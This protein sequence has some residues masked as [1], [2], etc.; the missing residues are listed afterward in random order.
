MPSRGLDISRTSYC[1]TITH[2]NG[3]IGL[4]VTTGFRLVASSQSSIVE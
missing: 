1:V 4:F 3:G 2:D